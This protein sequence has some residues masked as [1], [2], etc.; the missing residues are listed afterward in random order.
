MEYRCQR[1]CGY[2]IGDVYCVR[3]EERGAVMLRML[4]C[5]PCYVE[6]RRIGL[7]AERIANPNLIENQ[8][9]Q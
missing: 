7:R 6:A 3:S 8:M 2:I 1:C 4:V 5:Y 9:L